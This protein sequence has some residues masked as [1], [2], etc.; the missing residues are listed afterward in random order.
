MERK[1]LFD[2]LASISALGVV[3]DVVSLTNR[4]NRYIVERGIQALLQNDTNLGAEYLIDLQ[5]IGQLSSEEIAF[6]IGPILNAASRLSKGDEGNQNLGAR[7]LV[8]QA[9]IQGLERL[10]DSDNEPE[11]LDKQI[12]ALQAKTE[13]LAKEAIAQNEIRKHL[14]NKIYYPMAAEI[15][16][17]F[18]ADYK[19]SYDGK[20]PPAL[21]IPFSEQMEADVRGVVASRL[22]ENYALPTIVLE[23]QERGGE[24]F[25][26]MSCRSIEN[27][28]FV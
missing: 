9:E 25:Y 19:A 13:D 20:Q 26:K 28:A 7:I 2:N 11:D 3:P 27:V 1:E 23:P 15:A 4:T 8:K 6:K 16:E 5:D 14:G 12:K 10:R 17:Q 24:K 18:M 22:K 21:A